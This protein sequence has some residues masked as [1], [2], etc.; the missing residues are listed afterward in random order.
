MNS[1]YVTE[2][3]RLATYPEN[4]TCVID[5]DELVKAGLY[6]SGPDD[7]VQCFACNGKLYNWEIGDNAMIE[8]KKHFPRCAYV[9]NPKLFQEIQDM[10]LRERREV[11]CL[12][13]KQWQQQR[14]E[15]DHMPGI[16]E[17]NS[18]LNILG[19]LGYVE[20][21][22]DDA[23]IVANKKGI[24]CNV[25]NILDILYDRP[26]I[27]A[28]EPVTVQKLFGH[29]I[30]PNEAGMVVE[31]VLV[32]KVYGLKTKKNSDNTSFLCDMSC[33]VCM[34]EFIQV[35]FLPCKHVSCCEE[36]ALTL[37]DNRGAKCPVC[38]VTIMGSFR[39]YFQ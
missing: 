13:N 33:K 10:R 18:M 38:Q 17:Y 14:M 22:I 16:K 20:N 24:E 34:D 27:P 39:V 15:L 28:I 2:A 4:F 37:M 9:T 12:Q 31:S 6:Y 35:A 11:Q 1:I 5:K 25:S 23:I 19:R 7:K 30:S 29:T 8:H 32:P 21:E 26:E 36:C 3:A